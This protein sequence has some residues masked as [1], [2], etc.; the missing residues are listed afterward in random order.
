[1]SSSKEIDRIRKEYQRREREI[2]KDYYSLQNPGN[3][4]LYE[5]RFQDVSRMLKS[6]GVFPLTEKKILDVG[7]GA[8]QW[9]ADFK[10]WGAGDK[11]IFGLDLDRGRI[12]AAQAQFSEANFYI[13]EASNLP[14]GNASFDIVLQ[15]TVFS[16]VLDEPLKKAMAAE[17][18]RVVKKTGFVLWYDFFCNNPW[19]SNVRGIGA[20]EIKKLFPGCSINK[21][22]ITLAPPVAR[23]LAPKSLSLS[24]ALERFGILNTHYLALIRRD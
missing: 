5:Q 23:W 16:S 19:N 21:Q 7:C 14:F 2:P 6:S 15:S 17:M 1:M 18:I 3:R 10:K 24:R 13:G 12:A 20:E 8:G 4:F 9:I 22:R 11:D